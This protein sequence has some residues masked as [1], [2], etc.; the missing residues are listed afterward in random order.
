M[1]DNEVLEMKKSFF[2]SAGFISVKKADV[3]PA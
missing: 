1:R 2:I 3:K